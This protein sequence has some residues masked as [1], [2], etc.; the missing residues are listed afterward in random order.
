MS[1]VLSMSPQVNTSFLSRPQVLQLLSVSASTLY[2]WESS[3]EFPGAVQLGP[4]RVGYRA[5]DV[6]A[7]MESRPTAGSSN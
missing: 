3:G 2:R 1:K 4:R 7:W 6:N 5:A